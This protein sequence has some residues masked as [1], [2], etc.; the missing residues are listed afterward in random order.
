M[1]DSWIIFGLLVLGGFAIAA[2]AKRN[3]V[4]G[5]ED[6]PVSIENIRKGV[7]RGWYSAT[8]CRVDGMPAVRLVGRTTDIEPYT[9]VFPITEED[10]QTLKNEGYSVAEQ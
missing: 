2:S 7:A 9:D 3:S 4:D 5:M 8:L 1:M 10:W 6:T